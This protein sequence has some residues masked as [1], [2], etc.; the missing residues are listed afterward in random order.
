[1]K[2]KYGD[3]WTKLSSSKKAEIKKKFLN[4]Y[5]E[6]SDYGTTSSDIINEDSF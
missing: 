1:M 4:R 5:N 2:E 6:T 3:K